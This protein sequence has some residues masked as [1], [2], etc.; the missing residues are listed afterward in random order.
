ML[1]SK[2][3]G[4]GMYVPEIVVTNDDLSKMMDTTDEWIIERTGIKER[5]FFKEGV[6]TVSSMA[7]HAAEQALARAGKKAEEIDL[8]VDRKSVV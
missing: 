4:V 6:D 3:I 7:A 5:R 1:S 8:I 2:I